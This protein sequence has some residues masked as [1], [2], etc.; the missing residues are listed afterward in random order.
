[1]PGSLDF[2]LILTKVD[3]LEEEAPV[4]G[5]TDT[6]I[7]DT[8]GLLGSPEYRWRFTANWYHDRWSVGLRT[9]YLGEMLN[10]DT[11]RSRSTDCQS[12]SNCNEKIVLFLDGEYMH[13]LRVGYEMENLFGST[14]ASFYAGVNNI[15]DNQGPVLFAAH[16]LVSGCCDVGE[17]HHSIYDI[18]G[19]FYYAGAA[20]RF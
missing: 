20:F 3:E 8:T 14:D 5:T 12:F 13:N 11:S 1:M 9:S 18:T 17:N 2:G 4:P 6:F 19:R 7:T 16:D 15:T 10:D